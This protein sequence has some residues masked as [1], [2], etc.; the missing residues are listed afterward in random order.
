[1]EKG[2]IIFWGI[3]LIVGLLYVYIANAKLMWALVATF[4]LILGIMMHLKK[5]ILK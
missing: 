3:L 4:G 5:L 2:F 1:M